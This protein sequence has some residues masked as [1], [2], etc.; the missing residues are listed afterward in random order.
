LVL[1]KDGVPNYDFM[2]ELRAEPS[3][4][5]VAELAAKAEAMR[6]AATAVRV[7]ERPPPIRCHCYS[8]FVHRETNRGRVMSLL[9][10]RWCCECCAPRHQAIWTAHMTNMILSAPGE[11]MYIGETLRDRAA[12]DTVSQR[13]TRHHGNYA[14]IDSART[15]AHHWVVATEPFAG[16]MQVTKREAL[17]EMRR[18]IDSIKIHGDTRKPIATTKAWRL[19]KR[20]PT[21]WSILGP[22]DTQTPWAEI[23]KELHNLGVEPD[24]K[25]PRNPFVR[26][27]AEWV[28]PAGMSPAEFYHRLEMALLGLD[29][30][31]VT[32]FN[33][34]DPPGSRPRNSD[35][36]TRLIGPTTPGAG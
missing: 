16:G 21:G 23:Y 2:P 33:F 36:P 3:P 30:G 5:L 4:Q 1:I 17:A 29:Y 12:W 35:S 22:I 7:A 20:E 25:R 11:H 24:L 19:P 32:T 6:A 8:M 28:F 13:I 15:D 10:R 18:R 34:N 26:H 14:T 9:C 27:I 31:A